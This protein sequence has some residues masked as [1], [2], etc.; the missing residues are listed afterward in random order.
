MCNAT[1]FGCLRRMNIKWCHC[2]NFAKLYNNTHTV[3]VCV[4]VIALFPP[5]LTNTPIWHWS[6]SVLYQGR[7][8]EP[9]HHWR[10]VQDSARH[11]FLL[12]LWRTSKP[13]MRRER[14]RLPGSWSNKPAVWSAV[15]GYLASTGWAHSSL[16]WRP[17]GHGHVWQYGLYGVETGL[18]VIWW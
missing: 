13:H 15:K 3:R 12:P 16:T 10:R 4:L 11:W 9:R 14:E 8:W 1:H 5:L 18:M 2:D 17:L 7:K 6:V